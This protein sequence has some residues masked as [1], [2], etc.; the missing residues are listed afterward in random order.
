MRIKAPQFLQR[1]LK[2]NVFSKILSVQNQNFYLKREI[3]LILFSILS[4]F[5]TMIMISHHYSAIPSQKISKCYESQT[6]CN[7]FF[8]HKK[9]SYLSTQSDRILLFLHLKFP[10]FL[11]MVYFVGAMK[12]SRTEFCL[13]M[14][15]GLNTLVFVTVLNI[16]I[17]NLFKIYFS[18]PRPNYLEI[19]EIES[20]DQKGCLPRCEISR[21]KFALVS[22]FSGHTSEAFSI[23]GMGFFF[24]AYYAKTLAYGQPHSNH[25]SCLIVL[26]FF[27]NFLFAMLV[28]ILRIMSKN[29]FFEDV[30]VGAISGLI[31]GT[32]ASG[33]I[34]MIGRD[35]MKSEDSPVS[36]IIF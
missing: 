28:G 2:I 5:F 14:I 12:V 35:I 34:G 26:Y 10:M 33:L 8:G 16:L 25:I 9:N 30:F 6:N 32:C 4:I 20:C 29:H 24:L 3:F 36:L 19:C 17:T 11:V 13:Q 31:I 15:F 27:V 23:V 1:D 21:S 22:F 7:S 18:H